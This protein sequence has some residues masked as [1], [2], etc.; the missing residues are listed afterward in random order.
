VVLSAPP[1]ARPKAIA[2][3]RVR[4][5]RVIVVSVFLQERDWFTEARP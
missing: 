5:M 2:K 4:K 1:A 3:A